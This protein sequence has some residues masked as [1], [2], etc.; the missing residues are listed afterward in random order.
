MTLT[1]WQKSDWLNWP[2]FERLSTLRDELERLFDSPVEALA[3][4]SQFLN[5]WA[6]A[7]DLYED[8]DNFIVKAEV[9]GMTKEDIEVSLRE[10]VL[11]ISGERKGEEKYPE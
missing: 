7:I 9:P 10:G 2:S 4:P 8:K 1:R 3:R 11:S 5:G 6:P